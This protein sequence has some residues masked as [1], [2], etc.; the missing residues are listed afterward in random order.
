MLT[1]SKPPSAPDVEIAVFNSV[2]IMLS[3]IIW[4]NKNQSKT[5]R[6]ENGGYL[7]S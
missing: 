5:I 3:T 6:N 2:A 4:Y 1:I 7:C